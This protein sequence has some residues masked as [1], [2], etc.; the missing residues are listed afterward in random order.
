MICTNEVYTLAVKNDVFLQVDDLRVSFF[1]EEGELKAVDGVSF[2]LGRGGTLGIVGESGCGKS[3]TALSLIGL[4]PKPGR[5][6]GGRIRLSCTDGSIVNLTSL[7]PKSKELKGIRWREIAMIF[8]DPMTSLAPVYTVGDQITEALLIHRTSDKDEAIEI[9]L[10]MLR[11]V[12]ISNPSQRMDEYPHQLSA[13]MRQRV[14]I[15]MALSCNPSL[16]I[17]DEPTTALDV[18]VQAQ[19]LEVMKNVQTQFNMGIIYITHD[20][21][22]IAEMAEQ[23]A[24]MYLGQ[25]VEMA[26]VDVLF[27]ETLHPYTKGLFHSIPRGAKRGEKL[28]VIEGTV[29]L[30]IDLPTGCNFYSRC[31]ER[32]DGRCN[33]EPIRFHEVQEGHYVRCIQ[34]ERIPA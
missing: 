33:R 8:Q 20:L 19:V 18:T 12:G 6:V 29:P 24:V 28:H 5:I 30:P 7:R 32:I 10:D 25:I 13:G 4:V 23:V 15:A 27:Q 16:L 9:S 22:V 3:I 2:Q 17:A 21:G 26:P 14:M 34:F 31:P 11:R 1:L